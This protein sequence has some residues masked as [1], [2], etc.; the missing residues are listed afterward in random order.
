M[1]QDNSTKVNA[2]IE[3]LK[4]YGVIRVIEPWMLLLPFPEES[5]TEQ[6]IAEAAESKGLI[7]EATLGQILRYAQA[8]E[9]SQQMLIDMMDERVEVG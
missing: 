1:T 4:R 2:A 9:P 6:A 3:F 5:E 8:D 7:L